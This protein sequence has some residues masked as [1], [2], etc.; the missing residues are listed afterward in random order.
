[1]E[2]YEASNSRLELNACCHYEHEFADGMIKSR[3]WKDPRDTVFRYQVNGEDRMGKYGWLQ[4]ETMQMKD[5]KA[6]HFGKRN[7]IEI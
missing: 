7:Q 4:R 6:R 2:V 3:V 5:F 1:M